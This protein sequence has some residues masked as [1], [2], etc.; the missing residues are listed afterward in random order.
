MSSNNE[1]LKYLN[2]NQVEGDNTMYFILVY[3]WIRKL[4]LVET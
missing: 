1:V 3:N 4:F 2:S